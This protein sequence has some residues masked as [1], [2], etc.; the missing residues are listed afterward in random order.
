MNGT[1]TE[2]PLLPLADPFFIA[3]DSATQT[4]DD[5]NPWRFYGII[6]LGILFSTLTIV[7]NLMVSREMF[8]GFYI[9]RII[10]QYY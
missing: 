1:T 3:V 6:T 9:K 5:F 8:E 10:S 4:M 7:G 2:L